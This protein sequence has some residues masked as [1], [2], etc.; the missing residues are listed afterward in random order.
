MKLLK[1]VMLFSALSAALTLAGCTACD[2]MSSSSVPPEAS[3]SI[4]SSEPDTTSG[5]ESVIPSLPEDG[6][7][8]PPAGEAEPPAN[9]SSSMIPAMSADFAEIGALDGKQ[10]V[11]G[12]G[13]HKDANNHPTDI[14]TFQE[15]FGKYNCWFVG[16]EKGNIY[17]TFDEGYENGYTAKILDVLKDKKVPAIFFVTKHYVKTNPE[18]IQRMIDEGHIVGNHSDKHPNYTTIP[19]DAAQA[20]AMS[21]H[22]YVKENFNYNMSVFRYPEGAFSEQTVAL[23]NKMGYK[24]LFWSFAYND[25]DQNKQPTTEEAYNKIVSAAHDGAIYLLHAISKAN[26]EALP[27]AVDMLREKGFEF[28][29]F[30]ETM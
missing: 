20:D 5:E 3:S 16:K 18:L 26:T 19:L 22:N 14:D 8:M 7:S 17:L 11:W 24:Q 21:L 15:K 4:S 13:R 9:T 10:V 30:D 29:L 25:W 28:K 12:P 6:S 23:L 27:R 1:T 2:S